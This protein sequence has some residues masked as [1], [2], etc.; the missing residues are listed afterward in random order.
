[1][2]PFDFPLFSMLMPRG[3]HSRVVSDLSRSKDAARG[4]AAKMIEEG[5]Q[6]E[7]QKHLPSRC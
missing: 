2:V 4:L 6:D 7:G 5:K 1:M 3:Q